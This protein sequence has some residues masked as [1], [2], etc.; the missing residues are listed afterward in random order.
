MLTRTTFLIPLAIWAQSETAST[1]PKGNDQERFAEFEAPITVNTFRS[2]LFG[3]TI[4]PK[5]HKELGTS[6]SACRENEVWNGKVCLEI[7]ISSEGYPFYYGSSSEPA[8]LIPREVMDEPPVENLWVY[9]LDKQPNGSVIT[10]NESHVTFPNYKPLQAGYAHSM[11]SL[12]EWE[13]GVSNILPWANLVSVVS[14]LTVAALGEKLHA[15]KA[16]P[17]D[18][19]HK[20]AVDKLL[21]DRFRVT[22]SIAA[23]TK[24]AR[25][26]AIGAAVTGGSLGGRLT[27][28]SIDLIQLNQ[29]RDHVMADDGKRE[30][31]VKKASK[32]YANH[33]AS[34]MQALQDAANNTSIKSKNRCFHW[35]VHP[36]LY[37]HNETLSFPLDTNLVGIQG[38][39][40]F[41]PNRI[42]TVTTGT[43]VASYDPEARAVFFYYVASS[44]SIL[45]DK[46]PTPL[47]VAPKLFLG[48]VD[49][50]VPVSRTDGRTTTH[51][52]QTSMVARGLYTTV[53]SM[54]L[55]YERFYLDPATECPASKIDV[56]ADDIYNGLDHDAH[57][58]DWISSDV[59]DKFLTSTSALTAIGGTV[60]CA[61]TYLRATARPNGFDFFEYAV[62]GHFYM[63]Q[64]QES[65]LQSFKVRHWDNGV[66]LPAPSKKTTVRAL[67]QSAEEEKRQIA[68]WKDQFRADFKKR[69]AVIPADEWHATDS[70]VKASIEKL[71]SDGW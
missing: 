31:D 59:F 12:G 50:V 26:M 63:E 65:A 48:P 53:E 8:Y 42:F 24:H 43:V 21:E 13:S 37:V 14:P 57:E 23:A 35:E 41:S 71:L 69:I 10:V 16:S 39:V 70:K 33:K 67:Q 46:W 60:D 44:Q 54:P 28:A 40:S 38:E 20:E 19:S 58:A 18:I 11:H 66:I 4:D 3:S 32:S 6:R 22:N 17:S 2:L 30:V 56:Y 9:Y 27:D 29:I 45:P 51:T 55:D 61:I 68:Q 62:W 64:S 49:G 52:E 47:P 25:D 34:A 1:K 7:G 15:V 36:K 5:Q